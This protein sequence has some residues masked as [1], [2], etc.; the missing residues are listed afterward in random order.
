M[1]E[2]KQIVV[3]ELIIWRMVI[4]PA[5]ESGGVIERLDWE[6]AASARLPP[7]IRP[8]FAIP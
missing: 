3:D 2:I 4:S 6:V 1:S 5:S 7:P 8:I